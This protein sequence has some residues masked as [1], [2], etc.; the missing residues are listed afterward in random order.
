M[1][2]SLVALAL[3]AFAVDPDSTTYLVLNHGRPNH[4]TPHH[5]ALAQMFANHAAAAIENALLQFCRSLLRKGKSDDIGWL[6]P[7]AALGLGCEQAR[8]VLRNDFSLA[9][10]GASYKLKVAFCVADRFGLFCCKLHA[11]SLSFA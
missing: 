6:Q 10:S 5:A 8:N 11:P 3:A 9:R 1:L 2:S 4:Y 7:H